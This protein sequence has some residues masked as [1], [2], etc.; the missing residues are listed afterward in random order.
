MNYVW[1]DCPKCGCQI[2]I[3]YDEHPESLVGSVRRW[4]TDRSVNDGRKLEIARTALSEDGS[5]RAECVC[6]Y[7][8][9]FEPASAA[10]HVRRPAPG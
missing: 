9:G 7:G 3:Q 5:F 4:S 10:A 2:T 6:G 8:D 1:T